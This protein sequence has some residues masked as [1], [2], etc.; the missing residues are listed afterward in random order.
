MRSIRAVTAIMATAVAAAIPATA[1]AKAPITANQAYE[2][3]AP[4][5]LQVSAFAGSW[6]P[7]SGTAYSSGAWYTSTNVRWVHSGNT[8]IKVQF[9]SVPAGGLAFYAKNYNTGLRIGS[10]GY[11]P[12]INTTVTLGYASSGTPFVNVFKLQ[13][14]GK[15]TPYNFE[16]SEYY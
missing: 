12:P 16:G 11:F 4:A 8:A 10:I 7:I 9:S 14:T 15:G 6:T 3:P 5:S 2:S 1:S 13:N